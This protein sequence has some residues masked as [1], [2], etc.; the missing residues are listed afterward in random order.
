LSVRKPWRLSTRVTRA[1]ALTTGLLV[2]VIAGLSAVF[3]HS[4]VER[5]IAG[6]LKEELDELKLGFPATS[7]TRA[8]FTELVSELQAGHPANPMAFRVWGPDG[9]PWTEEGVRSLLSDDVPGTTTGAPQNATGGRRWR[10]EVLPTGHVVGIVIDGSTQFSLL[11]HFGLMTLG[12]ALLAGTLAFLGGAVFVRRSCKLLEEVAEQAR[13]VRSPSDRVEIGIEDAPEEIRAV[14]EALATMLANIRAE[15]ERAQLLTA[16]LAHELG[17]PVQNLIGEAQVALMG[18]RSVDEHRA[19]LESQLEELRDLARTVGNLV[20]LCSLGQTRATSEL[21]EFDLGEE[22]RMRLA[23]ERAHAR[24]HGVEL[25]VATH[26]DLHLRGD[27]EAMMLVVSNL[28]SNA[29][30]WSPRGGRVQADLEG[31]PEGIEVTVDDEGPGV[32]EADRER[33]FQAFFRGA[34]AAG[35]RHG[36]GLGLSIADAAV[37]AHGGRI[38]VERSPKGGARFR[39]GIPRRGTGHVE[40]AA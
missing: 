8:D 9:K 23:R 4:S 13:S 39:V 16:G 3:L 22:A 2:L 20:A 18:E 33:V 1:F 38:A 29:F 5:E 27:R 10:T 17:S 40:P 32:P 14:A 11:R 31:D 25:E 19:L 6:M 21:E 30:D 12:L 34:A 7:E 35:R 15:Y 24:R 28:V 37:R 26:G 36:Y